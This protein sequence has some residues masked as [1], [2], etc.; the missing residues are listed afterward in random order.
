MAALL[1]GNLGTVVVW[2]ASGF[3]INKFGWEFAFYAVAALTLSI[4]LAWAFLISDTPRTHSRINPNEIEYIEQSLA[5]NVTEEKV[6][7]INISIKFIWQTFKFSFIQAIPP[8][9][10]IAKSIPVWS[11]ALLHYGNVWGLFVLLNTAP[12]YMKHVLKFDLA[13]TGVL[14]S[15]PHLS[16]FLIGFMFGFIGDILRRNKCISLSMTRKVFCIFCMK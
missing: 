14:A 2:Q 5:G 8:Y 4:V 16:R 10:A 12:L 9:F 15:L 13:N 3:L 6:I 1:G 11:L 7:Q